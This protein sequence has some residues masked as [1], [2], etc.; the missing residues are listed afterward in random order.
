MKYSECCHTGVQRVREVSAR[1]DHH[2]GGVITGEHTVN[3][4]VVL[5]SS[6]LRGDS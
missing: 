6:W 4:R 5:I 2:I 1:V 3:H